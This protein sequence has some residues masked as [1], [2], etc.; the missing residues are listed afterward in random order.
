MSYSEQLRRYRKIVVPQIV[1]DRLEVPQARAC[2]RIERQQRICKQVV[3]F[4]VASV[5]IVAGG[6]KREICDAPLRIDCHLAPIVHAAGSLP[7]FWR[8]SIVAKFSGA[9]ND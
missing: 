7:G 1:V 6:P 9:R 4:T 2:A 5:E 3:A 8:P